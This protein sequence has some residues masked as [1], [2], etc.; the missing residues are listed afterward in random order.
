MYG[1]GDHAVNNLETVRREVS[2]L[3]NLKVLEFQAKLKQQD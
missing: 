2:S 3:M 1:V